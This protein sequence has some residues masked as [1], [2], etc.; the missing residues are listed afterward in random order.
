M[1]DRLHLSWIW[2]LAWRDGSS[3]EYVTMAL[4]IRVDCWSGVAGRSEERKRLTLTNPFIPDKHVR[5]LVVLRQ[6]N[7]PRCPAQK[8]G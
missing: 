4:D 1:K 3:L 2:R 7:I 8:I 6:S 5:F